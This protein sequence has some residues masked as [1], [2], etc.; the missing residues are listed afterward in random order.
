MRRGF[1][2]IELLVVMTLI[3]LLLSI[4]AP[5]Y[6]R[7]IDQTKETVLRE[8][9]RAMRDAIDKFRTDKGTYPAALND[10][11]TERYLRTVPEDPITERQDS[12][13]IVPPREGE[14]LVF[15]VHSGASGNSRNGRPYASF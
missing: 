7:H 13:V 9:L 10:L 12:W 14:R 1:T 8:N 2:I 4:A 5:R 15:D 11:V 3:A 6:F